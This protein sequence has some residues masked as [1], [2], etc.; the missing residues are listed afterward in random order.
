[1]SAARLAF[2]RDGYFAIEALVSPADVAEL[3]AA[4]DLLLGGAV[5]GGAD[6]RCLGGQTWQWVRPSLHHAVFADN[7]ALRAARAVAAEVLDDREPVFAFDQL[8]YKPPGHAAATP[9]HQDLAYLH[10]P[11]TRAGARASQAVVQFWLPLD[12]VDADTGCMHFLPGLSLDR[13][14]PH[15]VAAGA[16]DAPDRLL[17]VADPGSLPLGDAVAVP[18]RAGGCTGHGPG[19]LHYTSPNRSANRRRRAYIF[20]FARR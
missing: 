20:S 8:L 13:L 5:D 7:A 9:W 15:C 18:L 3:G 11:F 2:A 12:D 19:T 6:A 16:D 14:L 17:A 10:V 4:Y 1:M